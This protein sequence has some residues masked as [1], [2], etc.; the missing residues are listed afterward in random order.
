MENPNQEHRRFTSAFFHYCE[1]QGLSVKTLGHIRFSINLLVRKIPN[2][3]EPSDDEILHFFTSG[4]G[5]DLTGTPWSAYHYNNI[6]KYLKKFYQWCVMYEHLKKNPIE[7]VPPCKLP[8]RLPRRL[9]DEQK[10]KALYHAQNFPHGSSFLRS[11]NYAM[12]ATLLMTGLRVSE[13]LNLYDD[14][15]NL[16]EHSMRV[17]AGKGDKER[18]VYFGHNLFYI[19]RDYLQE[20]KRVGKESLHFFVSYGSNKKVDYGNFR[21]MLKKIADKAGL[22]ITAHQF[23][24]TCFSLMAEQGVDLETIRTLAGHSSITTT[25][26]Y[27][28]VSS[29]HVQNAVDK[30][31]FI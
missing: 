16:K 11:R 9:D 13:L 17:R 19:L 2:L 31:V 1:L 29:R 12:I 5:G 7:K 24:H 22:K 4:K 20:R 18:V 30:V 3:L 21:H 6:R 27:M 8:H 10:M 26:I 28:Q 14:D 25:Q 15:V 23:R